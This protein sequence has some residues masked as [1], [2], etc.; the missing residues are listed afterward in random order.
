MRQFSN[1]VVDEGKGSRAK[2]LRRLHH[3]ITSHHVYS[4]RA[5][6]TLRCYTDSASGEVRGADSPTASHALLAAHA[7]FRLPFVST[8]CAVLL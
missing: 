8:A 1:K 2:T 5:S 4:I 6:T 7:D 3:H